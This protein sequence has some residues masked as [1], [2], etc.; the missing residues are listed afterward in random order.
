MGVIDGSSAMSATWLPVSY[1]LYVSH[2]QPPIW[3][4]VSSDFILTCLDNCGNPGELSLLCLRISFLQLTFQKHP[5][6]FCFGYKPSFIFMGFSQCNISVIKYCS[7]HLKVTV[8]LLG[9]GSLAKPGAP[10]TCTEIL[11][12]MGLWHWTSHSH[13]I[14]HPFSFGCSVF[15]LQIQL[16]GR[17][18]TLSVL[19]R[20]AGCYCRTSQGPRVAS[21]YLLHTTITTLSTLFFNHFLVLQGTEELSQISWHFPNKLSFCKLL[22]PIHAGCRL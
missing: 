15:L 14:I 6:A 13:K 2:C 7:M 8:L 11:P 5:Y 18:E 3:E 22:W 1:R 19:N 12:H 10:W 21:T 20:E 4:G 17:K 9:M 16:L